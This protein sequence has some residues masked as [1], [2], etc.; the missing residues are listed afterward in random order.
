MCPTWW[1]IYSCLWVLI[2]YCFCKRGVQWTSCGLEVGIMYRTC[3]DIFP[4]C[5]HSSFPAKAFKISTGE[6]LG[7]LPQSPK[8]LHPLPI[9][10][11]VY[12]CVV[13]RIALPHLAAGHTAPANQSEIMVSAY[14][15]KSQWQDQFFFLEDQWQEHWTTLSKRPGRRRAASIAFGRFVAPNTIIP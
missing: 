5:C 8:D 14:M 7:T 12:G 1:I 2:N 6:Q 4:Q 3:W 11:S 15:S 13:S 10:F 9:S